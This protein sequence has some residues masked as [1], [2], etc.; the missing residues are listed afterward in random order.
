M[1]DKN[2]KNKKN[3]YKTL[4]KIYMK[5][6]ILVIIIIAQIIGNMSIW[7]SSRLSMGFFS[8]ANRNQI[9]E[10]SSMIVSEDYYSGY[11]LKNTSVYG[12]TGGIFLNYRVSPRFAFQP[13][14]SYSMQHDRLLYSDI[15]DFNYQIEFGYNYLMTSVVLKFYPFSNFYLGLTP[16]LGIN[17][18]Q[19][20][21]FYT[22]NGE[23]TY[24]PDSETQLLMRNVLK[25]R[26]VVS[27]G[28][29]LGYQFKNKWYL[30]MRYSLGL[31]DVI[32]TLPNSYNFIDTKNTSTGIQV[33]LGYG[34]AL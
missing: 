19:D 6:R 13:E 2:K 12:Y 27:M 22:S 16:Q 4:Y 14:V 21:L 25:G 29:G 32:E 8:G 9:A 20:D 10:L 5:Y 26:P 24:G 33:T 15:N 1:I 18:T 23:A 34:F 17:L 7:G 31:S 28:F 11:T 30:D 3:T